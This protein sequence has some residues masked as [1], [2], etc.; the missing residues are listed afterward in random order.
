MVVDVNQPAPSFKLTGDDKNIYS[1]ESF[2]GRNLVIY[3]YPRNNTSVC[4]L[5][6]CGFRDFYQQFKDLNTEIVGISRDDIE[7]HQ[8]FKAEHHLPFILLSDPNGMTCDA[9]GV[10]DEKTGKA[11]YGI[12]RS[13]FIIDKGGMIRHIWRDVSIAGHIDQVLKSIRMFNEA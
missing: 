5:E 1:L 9:Y 11:Y 4:T 12:V 6:S 13:T 10:S 8:K 2:K 3:F 7:S